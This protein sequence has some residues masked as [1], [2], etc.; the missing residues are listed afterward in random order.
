MT[1]YA[2]FTGLAIDTDDM[3]NATLYSFAGSAGADEGNLLWNGSTIAS[4]AWQGDM[5]SAS[6]LVFDVTG[7]ITSN[8]NV[9]GIQA[10]NNGGMAALQQILVV[11]YA[12]DLVVTDITV[13]VGSGDTWFA[14]EPNVISVT[15]T[16]QGGLL[17]LHLL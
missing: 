14:N 4:N 13:N 15:V 17:Q 6:A 10:T 11:E 3:V 8:G 12:P 7:Y 16:N 1:A 5:Y 9:A 2:P